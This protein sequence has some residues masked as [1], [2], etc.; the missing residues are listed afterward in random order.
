MLAANRRVGK[1][2]SQ[3]RGA[4]LRRSAGDAVANLVTALDRGADIDWGNLGLKPMN[5]YESSPAALSPIRL[6]ADTGIPFEPDVAQ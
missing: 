3:Q 5:G 1:R 4:A 2:L 6:A